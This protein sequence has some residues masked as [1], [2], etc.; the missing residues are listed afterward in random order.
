MKLFDQLTSNNH[1]FN[2][3]RSN[4]QKMKTNDDFTDLAGKTYNI[5]I[6]FDV[7]CNK[8]CKMSEPGRGRVTKP[9]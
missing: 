8:C 9:V 5:V 2:H 3:T 1:V 6:V 4:A 7:T